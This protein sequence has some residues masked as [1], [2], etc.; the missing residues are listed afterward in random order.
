LRSPFSALAQHFP[1]SSAPWSHATERSLSSAQTKGQPI[2]NRLGALREANRRNNIYAIRSTLAK[3]DVRHLQDSDICTRNDV[4]LQML[5]ASRLL[6]DPEL[7]LATMALLQ[8]SSIPITAEQ[9]TDVLQTFI[10]CNPVRLP[11]AL[12]FLQNHIPHD[13]LT[14][15][16]VNTV[17]LGV[18]NAESGGPE[19]LVQCMA[20]IHDNG[21]RK[22]LG[23]YVALMEAAAATPTVEIGLSRMKE[24]WQEI[25]DAAQEKA[26]LTHASHCSRVCSLCRLARSDPTV[27]KYAVDAYKDFLQWHMSCK[28]EW[29]SQ[30]ADK[31]VDSRPLSDKVANSRLL[32]ATNSVL[33]TA[34]VLGDNRVFEKIL[35]LCTSNMELDIRIYNQ[36]LSYNII[37][38]ASHAAI[39]SMVDDIVQAGLQPDLHTTAAL[40]RAHANAGDV[41][42]ALN[43]LE[44][45]SHGDPVTCREYDPLLR[46]LARQGK[47]K[48]A[49]LVYRC[50]TARK[51]KPDAITFDTLFWSLAKGAQAPPK[52]TKQMTSV[53]ERHWHRQ[54]LSDHRRGIRESGLPLLQ[55]WA[56]DMQ[57]FGIPHDSKTME[58]Y[59]QALGN[60]GEWK[61]VLEHMKQAQTDGLK[62][63]RQAYNHAIFSLCKLGRRQSAKILRHDMDT[64]GV[65]VNADT[66][67]SLLA[68]CMFQPD[69]LEVAVELHSEIKAM[70]VVPDMTL[71]NKLIEIFMKHDDVARAK[72][73]LAELGSHGFEPNYYTYWKIAGHAARLREHELLRWAVPRAARMSGNPDKYRPPPEYYSLPQESSSET[74]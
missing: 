5:Q 48:D 31:F 27:L 18:A 67:C 12:D 42:A 14:I 2:A 59:M 73:T 13:L 39:R 8:A 29:R 9:Y 16:H 23:T 10:R 21:L 61:A 20:L 19:A 30:Y 43:Q 6:G 51:V 26:I 74:A 40:V 32:K 56:A 50:M 64:F 36:I 49:D 66:Y 1:H 44:S 62:L 45:A 54:V 68:G 63:R 15:Q 7:A 24:L 52:P 11:E 17:M 4:L 34:R 25:K 72:A 35:G 55:E 37:K 33:H 60:L 58:S 46:A 41:Q 57:L 22:T 69:G 53:E 65:S 70:G 3:L 47:Y 38:G 28:E 71:Y